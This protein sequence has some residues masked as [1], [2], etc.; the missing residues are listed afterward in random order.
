M[1]RS[2]LS[3]LALLLALGWSVRADALQLVPAAT[4]RLHTLA[5]GQ[6]G[7]QWNTSG[8][9]TGGQLSFDS[10][11]GV[12]TLTGVLDVL[13]WF[14][15][16]N[17][18]CATDAGS[19]CA[20][21]YSPDLT[22]S[23]DAQYAGTVVT[24]VAPNLVNVTL[25]FATTAN[26]L[27]DLTLSDP[28]DPGFGNVLEGDWQAGLFNGNPTTGFS[29]SVLYNTLSGTA[30]FQT[31]NSSAFL[32]VDPGT[33]YASLFE[34]GSSYFGLNIASL[35]DFGGP[36]GNLSSIIASAIASGTLP[37]FTAEGNGQVYRVT[38]GEFVPEPGTVL[39][40]ASGLTLLVARRRS[41]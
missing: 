31:A 7:A 15:T 13:N 8:L 38:S 11:T 24:P 37:D 12:A 3:A 5:S 36:G 2:L 29:I 6:P 10:G 14:D 39:L 16:A 33:A 32:A 20:F 27:P 18:S 22:F 26:G 23:L 17:G 4:A 9:G 1:R 40:L 19:N 41:S 28:T 25:N 30:T 35:S 34:S 21:N